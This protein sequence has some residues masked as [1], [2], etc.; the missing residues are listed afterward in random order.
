MV[1]NILTPGYLRWDGT[2]FTTD[3]TVEIVG[4]PGPPGT[5]GA[6]GGTQTLAQTLALGNTTSSHNIVISSGD[7]IISPNAAASSNNAGVTLSITAGSG[8][9]SGKGGTVSVAGGAG[10]SSGDGG[11]II[12]N[13]G[14][15]ASGATGGSVKLH[16]GTGV[17]SS[18]GVSILNSDGTTALITANQ[19]VFITG[20]SRSDNIDAGLVSITGGTVASGTGNGG[21]VHIS[22]G[23]SPFS[24]GTLSI[25]D[26]NGN[27]KIQ[28]TPGNQILLYDNVLF[29]QQ[30]S[31]RTIGWRD[32]G[33]GNGF[34]LTVTAQNGNTV[35]NGGN[36]SLLVGAKGLS[37]TAD[38]NMSLL[39]TASGYGGMSKGIFIGNVTTA[40]TSDPTAGGFLYVEAGALKYRG[41]GGTITTLGPA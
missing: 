22:A 13:G 17:L 7:S 6:P 9:G 37:G 14:S 38:G 36:I 2:K 21:D 20:F 11:D 15:T 1:A 23:P 19:S 26:A 27:D 39:S 8:D 4:P 31:N 35:N 24:N 34:D 29:A 10:G 16:G 40:P 3:P 30:S 33:V 5:P 12:L 41:S 18:G 28:I 32:V 25:R